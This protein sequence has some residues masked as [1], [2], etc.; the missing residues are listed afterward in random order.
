[1]ETWALASTQHQKRALH[2]RGHVVSQVHGLPPIAGRMAWTRRGRGV[3]CRMGKAGR[4]P[5]KASMP[6][7]SANGIALSV[8]IEN[9]FRNISLVIRTHDPSGIGQKTLPWSCHSLSE[10][11]DVF[12][13]P[14]GPAIPAQNL[15]ESNHVP[16]S[17]HTFKR[18][19]PCCIPRW[20][21]PTHGGYRPTKFEPN[22]SISL[23]CSAALT[24]FCNFVE[25]YTCHIQP[26]GP[27]LT[28]SSFRRSSVSNEYSPVPIGPAVRA[29]EVK[30]LGQT[31]T[32]ASP[33]Y[34]FPAT[35]QSKSASIKTQY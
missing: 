8:K 33:Y 26:I 32:Q 22:Q 15:K 28:P 16:R 9:L 3:E 35:H 31:E 1:M 18:S 25:D 21:E 29:A 27:Q 34:L 14:I 7:T 30:M 2:D 24:I 17:S 23:A 4:R 6:V 13:A 10:S 19:A 12:P 11:N 20:I 5:A